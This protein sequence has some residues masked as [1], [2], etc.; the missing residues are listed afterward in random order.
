MGTRGYGQRLMK[1]LL[2][3]GLVVAVCAATHAVQVQTS[4]KNFF[5]PGS[6]PGSITQPLVSPFQCSQCHAGYNTEQAP[7]NR[8]AHSMMGQA[9]RDPVFHAALAIAEQD[10]AFSADFCLKCHVPATWLK[11]QVQ[12]ETN[13]ASPNYGKHL[14]L[15]GSQLD[16]TS[17]SVCHRMVDPVYTPGVSPAV[18][19][20]IIASIIPGPMTNPHN[21][22]FVIDPR[23]RRRGPFDLDADWMMAFGQPFPTDFH[24]WEKSPFH[25]ESRMCGTCHDVS[26][27]HFTRQADGS[28]ALNALG[29]APDSDKLKQFPEQ[30]T[31]S[32]WNASLFGQ[33]PVDLD[34][35]FGNREAV[36]SCQDCHMPKIEGQGCALNPPVRSDLP[37]HDF[38]GS[39]TWV[40]EAIRAT[41]FD[42]ETGMTEQGVVDAKARTRSMLER[43]SDM[44]LTLLDGNRLN[45]RV[46][47]YTGH[48][49]PT[50]YNEGR[51]MW[52][53][54]KFLD[55]TGQVIAERGGY[56]AATA[57]LE[58]SSTKVYQAKIGPDAALA[59]LLG[60]EAGPSFHLVQSNAW[61]F[62]NRIPPMGFSNSAFEAVQAGSVPSGQYADGQYWDDTPFEIPAG[63]SSVAVTLYYQT[64][65]REYIEF[66]RDTN[67]SDQRGQV[68]Y[69]LW[70]MFGKSAPVAMD[71]ENI[72]LP[73][74]CACDWDHDGRAEVQDIFDFLASWF[75]GTGDFDQSGATDV[76]DIIAFLTCWFAQ[77]GP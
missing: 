28:Y 49:L 61:Y 77:C 12:F 24:N 11:N 60:T 73:V 74:Q 52:L 59:A 71:S 1:G 32:E 3:G 63:A 69:D 64:T 7:F 31:F 41:Y 18:D 45:V 48:K 20:G 66:L 37:Q 4:R 33:G 53:N 40:L 43:A 47:N 75:S 42:S 29:A 17:C 35:R 68:A 30:R 9:G 25:R 67:T 54:V 76:N 56:N 44:Q 62:D 34:G 14:P 10:A 72:V 39:N 36:S 19:E 22:G 50:G 8:W 6:Q 27:P 13:Q 15:V 5:H 55:G 38:H 2:A 70:A 23:D 26:T 57:T 16:G 21:A 46:I 58:E 51:R 65:S